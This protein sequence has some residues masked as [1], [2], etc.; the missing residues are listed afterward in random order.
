MSEIEA[1]IVALGGMGLL[2]IVICAISFAIGA[3]CWPY[4]INSWLVYSGR[5]PIIEW[6]MGGLMGFVPCIGQMSIPAAIITFVLMLFL[7]A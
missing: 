6:W 1:F 4:T 7:G 5:P 3:V 2:I